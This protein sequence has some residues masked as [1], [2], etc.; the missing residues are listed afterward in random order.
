[1]ENLLKLVNEFNRLYLHFPSNYQYMALFQLKKL[2]QYD[3]TN[4][5]L[6]ILHRDIFSNKVP[7]EFFEYYWEWHILANKKEKMP[8]LLSMN[9]DN[10]TNYSQLVAGYITN[11]ETL[12]LI[13]DN[14]EQVC[15]F[16]EATTLNID[17]VIGIYNLDTDNFLVQ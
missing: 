14:K 4:E 15:S 16:E 5:R 6:E 2:M 12:I 3:Y 9:K 7:I 11:V 10:D 17:T 1:M 13:V 8:V